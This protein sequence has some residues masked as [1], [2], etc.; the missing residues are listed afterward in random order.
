MTVNK[1]EKMLSDFNLE[2]ENY[3]RHSVIYLSLA[4]PKELKSYL[5]FSGCPF[6]HW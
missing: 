5:Y 6:S 4:I 3:L 1:L 2:H